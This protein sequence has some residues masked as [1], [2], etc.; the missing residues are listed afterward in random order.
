MQVENSFE[1]QQ[2]TQHVVEGILH[3]LLRVVGEDWW[4]KELCSE[5]VSSLELLLETRFKL[6][7]FNEEISKQVSKKLK[8]IATLTNQN[9]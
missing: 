8:K 7:L 9:K 1:Q 4:R 3:F 5:E 6:T 2:M